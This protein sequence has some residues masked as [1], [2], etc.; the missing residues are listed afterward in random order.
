MSF[1]PGDEHHTYLVFTGN[2]IKNKTQFPENM[3]SPHTP[4]SLPAAKTWSLDNQAY[5]AVY[6]ICMAEARKGSKATAENIISQ[7]RG[8]P[9]LEMI[10]WNIIIQTISEAIMDVYDDT[11]VDGESEQQHMDQIY[12]D[13]TAMEEAKEYFEAMEKS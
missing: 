2:G 6:A 4:T 12:I 7:I 8:S 5:K 3:A 11:V 10:S 1:D 13:V 9:V